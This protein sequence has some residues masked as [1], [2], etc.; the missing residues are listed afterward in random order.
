MVNVHHLTKN[1]D[2]ALSRAV[3]ALRP[4]PQLPLSEWLEAHLRLPSGLSAEGG[5]IGP[6][7]TQKGI[8]DALADPSIERTN[9]SQKR[10]ERLHHIAH[11]LDRTPCAE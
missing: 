6:W 5:L 8:A 10:E 11:R 1:L 2:D 9:A 7:P 3:E 4:P